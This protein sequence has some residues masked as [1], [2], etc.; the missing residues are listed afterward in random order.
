LD[1][2]VFPSALSDRRIPWTITRVRNVLL[3]AVFQFPGDTIKDEDTALTW[4]E[5]EFVPS[6]EAIDVRVNAA[7]LTREIVASLRLARKASFGECLSLFQAAKRTG[8]SA[9]HIG[10]LVRQGKVPN[11]GCKNAPR[12][13]LQDLVLELKPRS[14]AAS[15]RLYDPASDAR[16]LRV[17]R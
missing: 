3:P 5:Q 12:V 6:C 11:A 15:T 8:Y 13:R 17:R 16:R 14:E 4:W 1:A 7:L 10:R 9:D 2:E